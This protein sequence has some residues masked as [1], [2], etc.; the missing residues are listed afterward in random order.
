MDNIKGRLRMREIILGFLDRGFDFLSK[1]PFMR[2]VMIALW[3]YSTVL[4]GFTLLIR[5]VA[6]FKGEVELDRTWIKDLIIWASGNSFWGCVFWR[7]G[8]R[9]KKRKLQENRSSALGN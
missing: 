9:E 4:V 3:V 5:G 1:I 7:W 2:R 8:K 6:I